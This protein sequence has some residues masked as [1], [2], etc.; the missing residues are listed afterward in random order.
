M[1]HQSAIDAAELFDRKLSSKNEVRPVPKST[2]AAREA[3]KSGKKQRKAQP[4]AQPKTQ[5]RPGQQ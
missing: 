4:K 3:R 1:E 5:R 2:P